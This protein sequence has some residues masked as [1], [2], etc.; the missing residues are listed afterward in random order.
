MT[1]FYFPHLQFSGLPADTSPDGYSYLCPDGHLQPLNVTQPCVWVAKPW[2]AI[3]ARRENAD[4]I[5]NLVG[6]LTH[7]V[8]HSW[9]NA[10]LSLLESYHVNVTT[11]DRSLPIDDYL[12]QATGFQ[13]AY[14]FP[15]CS[16]PR[17][18]V[19]C[20]SSLLQHYKC[21][22]LQ[23]AAAVY[24]IEP[25]IQCIRAESD[26]RCLA[27]VRDSVADVV[28][29]GQ[30]RRVSAQ[31]EHGLQ[32]L[33][34]EYAADGAAKYVPVAVVRADSALHTM[35]DLRGKRAC[36]GGATTDGAAF[37]SVWQTL[38]ELHLIEAP[39]TQGGADDCNTPA[40]RVS[41]FFGAPDAAT[42]APDGVYAGEMGALR[43]LADRRADVA[44]VDLAAF[45]NL[46][47]GGIADAWVQQLPLVRLL[48]PFGLRANRQQAQEPCYLHW[49]PRGHFMVNANIGQQR[50]N[51]IYN[52]MRE[53]DKLF[54]KQYQTHT[55]PF[56][57]FGPFDR[58]N[59]V[60]FRDDTE[61]LR[62]LGE[63]Q[64]DRWARNAEPAMVA[65]A[66]ASRRARA[67]GVFCTSDG[68]RSDAGRTVAV[69]WAI[70]GATTVL[71]A[72]C[73][74]AAGV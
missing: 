69:W 66:N 67:L 3:A 2:P 11:L 4:H 23:E 71:V 17:S 44:F 63:L 61:G 33:M 5:Q 31:I 42:A 13:S 30:D 41:A 54:G 32:P 65:Y 15:S 22:W 16:P 39:T 24:G 20:T 26:A 38:K 19:Y 55:I 28:V 10:L 60:M 49:T 29:V 52:S 72:W 58:R 62:S 1:I 37:V 7:N 25:N 46:T 45:R 53:M 8:E 34:Y 36:F 21:S 14:S 74:A 47:H 6:G 9:Q 43:C 35:A 56:T 50:R 51:E 48:C 18:I 73:G 27:D 70:V 64:R 57:M 59:N 12:D 40:K 68:G